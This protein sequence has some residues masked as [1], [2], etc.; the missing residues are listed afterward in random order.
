MIKLLVTGFGPFGE[1]SENPSQLLAESSGAPCRILPVTFDAVDEFVANVQSV[2]RLVMIGVH[3]SA[4]K[5][6]L[7]LFGRNQVGRIS[8]VSGRIL[9]GRI[10]PAGPAMIRHRLWPAGLPKEIG[11]ERWRYSRSAGSYLCN[12]LSYRIL[13]ARPEIR[14]GFL[15]IP[16]LEVVPLDRQQRFLRHLLDVLVEK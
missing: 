12:Y 6:H 5:F 15:H 11:G 7:E 13:A 16:S 10:D 9:S 1:F 14:A 3:G 4:K 8:D 2:D